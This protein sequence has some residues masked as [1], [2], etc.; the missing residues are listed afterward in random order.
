[1]IRLRNLIKS[2][3]KLVLTILFSILLITGSQLG[4]SNAYAVT[5]ADFVFIVDA[6]SSMA[7][8]IA[9]VRAGLSSF[10]TGLNVANVDARFAVMLYGGAPELV[11]DFTSSQATTDTTF[12]L[13]SVNS[14]VPGFQNNHNLNPE[15]G[16]E[17]IRIALGSANDNTLVRNNV[18]GAG[19]LSYRPNA[20]RNLILV[21]DEDS[22]R[23]FYAANRLAG[24][25]AP[26]PPANIAGTDWQGEVDNTAADIIQNEAFL[27]MLISHNLSSE[28][29]YGDYIHDVS[30][31]DFLNYDQA[32]TLL[33]LQVNGL[34]NSLQAQVLAGNLIARSFDIGSVNNADFIDNFFAAKIEETITNP[35]DPTTIPEPTTM[36]LMG[37]GF[38]GTA[39]S[40]RKQ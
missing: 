29:Q 1:M 5:F 28:Q 2:N 27:N 4:A 3:N 18:G 9:A 7:G 13:I 6:T 22:D 15:A 37:L 26:A 20:R 14:A 17:A 11:Q 25:G 21:T 40:R 16:L 38:L 30:D 10:V 34:G 19:G 32:A 8:E 33:A 35:V 39:W 36:L 12:G 31:P 24:Q 23:P